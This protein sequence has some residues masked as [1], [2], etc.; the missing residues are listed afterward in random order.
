MLAEGGTILLADLP[1]GAS[2][3]L[4]A[5]APLAALLIV[6]LLPDAAST[7]LIPEIEQGRFLAA[8][9]PRL[10]APRRCVVLNQ[11]D[12]AS[13]LSR[14]T[15]AKRWT[16]HPASWLIGATREE[17]VAEALAWQKPLLAPTR[18]QAAA[19]CV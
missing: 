15:A 7:A 10:S 3:V 13:P 1:P 19:R 16:R 9:A 4:A 2:P 14:R 18:R 5:L 8:V 6:V 12:H 11:R 17:A